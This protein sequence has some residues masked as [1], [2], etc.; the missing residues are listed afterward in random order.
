MTDLCSHTVFC[1]MALWS[2]NLSS[3]LDVLGLIIWVVSRIFWV[4]SSVMFVSS[5]AMCYLTDIN[6]TRL[7]L[8]PFSMSMCS[9]IQYC[10]CV[11]CSMSVGLGAQRTFCQRSTANMTF[12]KYTVCPKRVTAETNT[13][14]VG[15]LKYLTGPLSFQSLDYEIVREWCDNSEFNPEINLKKISASSFSGYF[16]EWYTEFLRGRLLTADDIL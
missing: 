14:D 7:G 8:G 9:M 11:Q 13:N 3:C 15:P 1:L 12:F 6:K 2:H 10:K 16:V 5:A 4:A